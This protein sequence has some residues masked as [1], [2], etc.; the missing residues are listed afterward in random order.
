MKVAIFGA[1]RLG[2]L[3]ASRIPGTY[4]KVIIARRKQN[5]AALADEVGGIASDQYSAVRGCKVVLLAVPGPAVA[6]VLQELAP[7]LDKNA[8]V[9]N[10]ATDLDTGEI[11]AQFLHLRIAAAKLI[12]HAREMG[13]GSPGIVMI[14]RVGPEEEELL[15]DLLGS[16]GPVVRDQEHKVRSANT[17]VAEE[18]VMAEQRL[19]ARLQELGLEDELIRIAIRTTAPG[20]LRSLSSGDAGPFVKEIARRISGN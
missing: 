19:R 18:M 2:S 11:A 9:V 15:T 3:L 16:L 10:M 4:R 1:G 14:D 20:I 5:A 17:A 8:L 6:T 13:H 7:H 12:G